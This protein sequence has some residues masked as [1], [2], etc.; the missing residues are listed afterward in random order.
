MKKISYF[1]ALLLSTAPISA[2]T[3]DGQLSEI[4]YISLLKDTVTVCP[5]ASNDME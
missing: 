1:L 4:V 5:Y 2:L 3:S